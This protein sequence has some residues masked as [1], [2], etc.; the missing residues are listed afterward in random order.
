MDLLT[1]NKTIESLADKIKGK[2]LPD[3]EL[4]I[5]E[6]LKES[7]MELVV[8]TLQSEI[9]PI[10]DKLK[11]LTEE[12]RTLQLRVD[13]LETQMR[14]GNLVFHGVP[15]SSYA[16]AASVA[17]KDG[18]GQRPSS[19][20]DTVKAV[21]ECCRKKLDLEISERDITAGFRVPG[22]KNAPRPIVVTF[23]SRLVRDRIYEL[24]RLLR[25]QD[26]AQR[27]YINEHLTK[28]NADIFSKGRKLFKE[29]RIAS[30]WTWNGAVFVRRAESDRPTRVLSLEEVENF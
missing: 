29:K 1:E 9:K 11:F 25:K 13:Q 21:I 3:L 23:A 17:S 20:Q 27:V 4:S 18:G 2:I 10:V 14:S 7:M 28:K 26:T 12:N 5:R 19:R 6:M 24:R 16:E 15:E 22:L 30:I 8:K